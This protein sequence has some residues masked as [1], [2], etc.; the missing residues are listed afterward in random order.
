MR[1]EWVGEGILVLLLRLEVLKDGDEVFVA[2]IVLHGDASLHV[3]HF[4]SVAG[5]V[6]GCRETDK[7]FTVVDCF[8]N[9]IPSGVGDESDNF[10]AI[11]ELF[12]RNEFF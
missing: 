4:V 11:E 3:F 10:I 12:L 7:K 2:W 9:G 6:F 5:L 1:G 8:E